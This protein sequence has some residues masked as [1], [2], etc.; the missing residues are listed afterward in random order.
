MTFSRTVIFERDGC[1]GRCARESG[2]LV[3]ALEQEGAI[4]VIAIGVI[5]AG[6]AVERSFS[7]AVG[8]DQTRDHTDSMTKS[9]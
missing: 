1:F 7:S 9:I 5:K 2:Y 8:P 4:E 3:R 6:N